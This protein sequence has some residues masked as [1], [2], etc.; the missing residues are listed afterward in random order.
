MRSAALLRPRLGPGPLRGSCS[1]S[2]R[3]REAAPGSD[4]PHSPPGPGCARGRSPP[5]TGLPTR[6]SGSARPGT[7]TDLRQQIQEQPEAERGRPRRHAEPAEPPLLCSDLGRAGP[8]STGHPEPAP[9]VPPRHPEPPTASAG[10]LRHFWR[11]RM[12]WR[13][14]VAAAVARGRWR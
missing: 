4:A 8:F 1:T 3:P 14:L 11:C 6:G 7:A 9:D 5:S 10:A 13:V 12:K 2:E